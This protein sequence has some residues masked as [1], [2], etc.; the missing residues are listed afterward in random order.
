MHGCMAPLSP[1]QR[2]HSHEGLARGKHVWWCW[3]AAVSWGTN[4]C[5][6]V[7]TS[8]W[9]VR[10]MY[11]FLAAHKHCFHQLRQVGLIYA[12]VNLK[13]QN[14]DQAWCTKN[15]SL[16]VPAAKC[17]MTMTLHLPQTDKTKWKTGRKGNRLTEERDVQPEK[18]ERWQKDE[19]ICE[20]KTKQEEIEREGEKI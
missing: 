2:D 6:F 17:I 1:A 8:N 14:D 19:K 4:H 15:S 5:L 16:N 18:L 10:R 7:K 20:R 11:S 3:V 9:F 13:S 12:S